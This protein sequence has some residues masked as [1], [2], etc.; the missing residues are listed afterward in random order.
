MKKYFLIIFMFCIV[1]CGIEN[2]AQS[3]PWENGIIPYCFVDDFTIIE[4]R[5]IEDAMHNWMLSGKVTFIRNKYPDTFMVLIFK[6]S[7]N[8]AT[9]GFQ[10]NAELTLKNINS[11]TVEHE[12]GHVIGL[13]HEHQ[14]PDRDKYISVIYENIAPSEVDQF[15]PLPSNYW[16]YKYWQIP[17]DYNSIMI[18]DK[19]TFSINGLPTIISTVAIDNH[20]ISNFDLDKVILMYSEGPND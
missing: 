2:T 17:F 13:Q 9:M 12:L 20:C 10:E 8:W 11:E 5:V 1:G 7:G 16:G 19:N 18:Y 15:D 4:Q 6:G 3:I 14:R